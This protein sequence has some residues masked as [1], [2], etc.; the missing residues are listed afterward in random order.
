MKKTIICDKPLDAVRSKSTSSPPPAPARKFSQIGQEQ[1][2]W[3]ED[4][5]STSANGANVQ[6]RWANEDETHEVQCCSDRGS[7]TRTT[8][9]VRMSDNCFSSTIGCFGGETRECNK[10]TYAEAKAICEDN[11]LRLCSKEEVVNPRDH[12]CCSAGCNYDHTT[13]WT[14]TP[15][16]TS[17]ITSTSS[18]ATTSTATATSTTTNTIIRALQ[19]DVTGVTKLLEEQIQKTESH[20]QAMQDQITNLVSQYDTS[21]HI[22]LLPL[23]GLIPCTR[24]N[25][26]DRHLM[27]TLLTTPQHPPR[28]AM[29]TLHVF[30]LFSSSCF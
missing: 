4:G 23:D 24:G 26:R 18:T 10:K 1:T 20:V 6:G 15:S 25:G 12:D 29:R 7:C 27:I 19:A 9:G 21:L 30:M 8:D 2:R 28:D 5:C 16:I 14:S 22:Y 13:V 17:T 3:V 11:Q